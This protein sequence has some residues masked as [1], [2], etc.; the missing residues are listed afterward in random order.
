MSP[1][2]SLQL[3]HRRLVLHTASF[4]ID[5]SSSR[6]TEKRSV[7][8]AWLPEVACALFE[9]VGKTV[10]VTRRQGRRHR[11]LGPA[12]I[13]IILESLAEAG[14][15]VGLPRETATLL[16]AQTALGDAKVV[17]ATGHHPALLKDAVTTLRETA[18][19]TAF[20]S[21]KKTSCA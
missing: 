3:Y 1:L 5:I 8:S 18:P 4:T 10:V 11:P 9:R 17:L 20:W 7:P 19:S 14:L 21:W 12:F 13:Y 6:V 15:K 2:R 16:V